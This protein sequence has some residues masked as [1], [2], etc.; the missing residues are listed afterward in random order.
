MEFV[1]NGGDLVNAF[2]I[3]G[4]AVNDKAT[5]PIM[6]CI[7]LDVRDNSIFMCTTNGDISI[8]GK[9]DAN[10]VE[11]GCCVADFITFNALLKGLERETITF[12]TKDNTLRANY[13]G[14]KF[15]LQLANAEDFPNINTAK[16][17]EKFKIGANAL[18]NLINNGGMAVATDDSRPILKGV[19]FE[20]SG[21][22]ISAVSLDG[23][24]LM[25]VKENT[26][27]V[28]SNIKMVIPS[29]AFSPINKLLEMSNDDIL[30][31]GNDNAV[32]FCIDNYEINARLL[33]GNFIEY[34]KII[35]TTFAT[36]V[37]LSKPQLLM[38]LQRSLQLVKTHSNNFV[39]L[40]ITD[41][42]LAV[43]ARSE[44]GDLQ[45][46]IIAQVN[47][48]GLLISFNAK[49]LVEFLKNC[50][51]DYVKLLLNQ[52]YTPCVIKGIDNDNY[53]YLVLPVRQ[54]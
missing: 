29:S 12:E 10:V 47:G 25:R 44:I 33:N 9:I 45:E 5:N 14:S 6:S 49:F 34:Q 27:H 39:S 20:N 35:P 52:S 43:N 7:K 4:G 53:T 24:R 16:V 50:N 21:N 26:E 31:E 32:I 30:V 2:K 11:E 8:K 36:E 46:K 42:Y 19:L 18:K 3:M 22:E 48:N 15:S 17:E 28:Y 40:N 13:A 23:F 51:D 41:D 38:A 54:A 1:C 37:I